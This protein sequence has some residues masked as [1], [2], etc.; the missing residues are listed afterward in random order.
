[1]HIK[2]TALAVLVFPMKSRVNR[3]QNKSIDQGWAN[4]SLGIIFST[5]KIDDQTLKN[6]L[7]LT[8]NRFYKESSKRKANE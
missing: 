3:T 4:F 5:I 1:M 8:Q 2:D 6:S 7:E